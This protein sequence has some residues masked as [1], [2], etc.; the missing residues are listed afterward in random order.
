M[1]T[2]ALMASVIPGAGAVVLNEPIEDTGVIKLL[3]AIRPLGTIATVMNTAAHPDDEGSNW[4]AAMS[5]GEGADCHVV[6]VTRGQGGQNAILARSITTPWACC[7]PRSSQRR[8]M[9]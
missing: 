9:C 3:K 8:S 1:L 2:L 6:T 4:L 7:A 5:L